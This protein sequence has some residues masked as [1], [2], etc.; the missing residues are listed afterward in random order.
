MKFNSLQLIN[1]KSFKDTG[2]I[3]LSNGIN[4]FIGNN[5]AGKS[6]IISALYELQN[7]KFSNKD[8]RIGTN[9]SKVS[10][11]IDDDSFIKYYYESVNLDF[12]TI[13][14][15][16]HNN[17]L[18]IYELFKSSAISPVLSLSNTNQRSK[19]EKFSTSEP[20]NYFYLFL[21]K[22]KVPSLSE[23]INEVTAKTV[24]DNLINLNSK[25]DRIL[26]PQLLSNKEFNEVCLEILGFPI[27]SFPS[28]NG[29]K[30]GI[31]I[32][33]YN[34]IDLENMGEGTANLLG[35]I[36]DL[37]FAE[38]KI[39]LIEEPEN[40]IQPNALKKLLNFILKKSSS[41]QFFITS[42]SN[43]V[44]KYLGADSNSKIFNL[45]LSIEQNIP[46]STI[47]EVRSYEERVNSLEK[48][49]YELYDFDLWRAWLILEESSAETL[50]REYF[51]KWYCPGLF[52]KLRTI[53]AR[54]KD[55]VEN[56]F[57]DFERLFTFI[58]LEPAYKNKAWV[59]VDNNAKDI[60]ERL[61]RKYKTWPEESFLYFDKS[62]FEEY[63]P[64]VFNDRIKSALTSQNK[65]KEKL[66]LL[67][68]VIE[69]IKEDE[70]M[71]KKEF[72]S[73]AAEI[74]EILKK[75]EKQII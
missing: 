40:D 54:G 58:H 15:K 36:V 60:I 24:T 41:N 55:R 39:F 2:L 75:I 13:Y 20:Y 29:K 14:N 32:D 69:W 6:T 45:D 27:S 21:A 22:R 74:I 34:N 19:I 31:T 26:S 63:Y 43:I 48:L 18:I 3:N 56:V 47:N 66:E 46:T 12:K 17:I 70:T 52:N 73:S 9:S 71:A 49:G 51:I 25:I 68:E 64:S 10:I 42:H 8:I 7:P 16:F 37:C 23:I 11:G 28:Q 5:N 35:L 61:R 59:V 33:N 44:I 1:L 65:Q 62:D 67:M 72:S 57:D 50:I 4:I 38:N 53:S 30:A